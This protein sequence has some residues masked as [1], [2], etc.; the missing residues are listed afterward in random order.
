VVEKLTAVKNDN[1]RFFFY[2]GTSQPQSMVKSW[3]R[4]FHK[5][6]ATAKLAIKGGHPH[7]FRDTFA[8]SLLL[9]GVSIEIASK[10]LGHS[11]IKVTERHYS[12]SA[13][14][15]QDQL[16]T[17]VRRIWAAGTAHA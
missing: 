10:L 5:V 8:F 9:K 14:A 3:D 2:D 1:E 7:R 17:E 4:I 6:F 16:E 13:K 11:S 12:P 15:R